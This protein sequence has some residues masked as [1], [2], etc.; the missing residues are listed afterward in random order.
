MPNK[1]KDQDV[2]SFP[3]FIVP[4]KSDTKNKK[5]CDQWAWGKKMMQS[6]KAHDASFDE[7]AI[8]AIYE[9]AEAEINEENFKH[10]TEVYSSLGD[11]VAIPAV[12]RNVGLYQSI[13]N[14]FCAEIDQQDIG[15]VISLIN[16]DAITEDL[17]EWA[18]Q[19]ADRITSAV[20]KAAKLEEVIG[21]HLYEKDEFAED[22]IPEDDEDMRFST[23]RQKDIIN[24]QHGLD[25]LMSESSNTNFRYKITEQ[26][27]RDFIRTGR[28]AAH[29]HND[30]EDPNFIVIHPKDLRYVL[31]SNNPFLHQGIAVWY[32]RYL[33]PQE[34]IDMCPNLDS[35]E[36][37][38]L[39]KLQNDYESGNLRE[40]DFSKYGCVV[41]TVGD[42]K[43]LT[44][45]TTYY[46]WRAE[47]VK[48]VM[49]TKNKFDKDNDYVKFVGNDSDVKKK[50][51]KYK[52]VYDEEIWE[53]TEIG[54]QI[55]YEIQPLE[56][57][58]KTKEGRSRKDF[59]I[60]GMVDKNPCLAKLIY[61][62]DELRMQFFFEF[63]LLM[64][65]TKGNMLFVDEAIESNNA[66]NLYLSKV[67][68]IWKY[69]SAKEGA[70][71]L[72]QN[73]K[74]HIDD[75]GVSNAIG[76]VIGAIQFIDTNIANITGLNNTWRTGQVKSGQ[77]L[78]V[79]NASIAQAQSS[80]QMYATKWG[81]IVQTI[82]QKMLDIMPYVWKDKDVVKNY[83]GK[84]GMKMLRMTPDEF[85]SGRL[86]GAYVTS[87]SADKAKIQNY[88]QIASQ[89]LP[90]SGD[91]DS[92]M[93]II[94]MSNASNSTEA[95]DKFKR[96]LAAM[97]KRMEAREQ[98]AAQQAQANAMA[99]AE[100]R[101][102]PTADTKMEVEGRI[103]AENIRAEA[104]LKDTEM[105][106]D[107]KGLLQDAKKQDKIDERM[108]E[109]EI[110]QQKTE[111]K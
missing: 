95:M 93:S 99:V 110:N 11:D 19:T 64:G 6:L 105:K 35:E 33:T 39:E 12:I 20:R 46:Q 14:T 54:G 23:A 49:I 74:P 100:A 59:T 37:E 44:I 32:D 3:S 96:S 26:L 56:Y 65:Q 92:A 40:S 70:L 5:K 62:L 18:K 17:R 61:P 106:L 85:K 89:V 50:G 98:Q 52:D 101:Q 86:Y 83:M 71:Q 60:V 34:V 75:W 53:G 48:R 15:F 76:E 22:E 16:G 29:V 78:G 77:G 27:L 42:K 30:Y 25:Y 13:E 91:M 107:N 69:N 24:R 108:I 88:I 31:K 47:A 9:Y 104:K 55:W 79:T 51:V 87:S 102:Q 58:V 66:E 103:Q 82:L 73:Q 45:K 8:K 7:E 67:Y 38:L 1:Y 63:E 41:E 10:I 72:G 94:E 43:M 28:F 21:E 97:R 84:E 109:N 36:V 81:L 111:S 2:I 57:Q 68:N 80:I 4:P 90:V